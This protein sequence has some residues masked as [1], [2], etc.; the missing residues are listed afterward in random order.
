MA[1]IN[2]GIWGFFLGWVF[3]NLQKE[4]DKIGKSGS[5]RSAYKLKKFKLGLTNL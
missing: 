2:G 3:W 5:T 4:K 1:E